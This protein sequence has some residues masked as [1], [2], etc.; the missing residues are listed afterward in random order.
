MV[1]PACK[2]TCR[3]H[4]VA[5]VSL[6]NR[7]IW[8]STDNCAILL[9]PIDRDLEELESLT[10]EGYN[11]VCFTLDEWA[12]IN[13]GPGA[14]NLGS[15]LDPIYP[16]TVPQRETRYIADYLTTLYRFFIVTGDVQLIA[17]HRAADPNQKRS[18]L[19]AVIPSKHIQDTWPPPDPDEQ[20]TYFDA[21]GHRWDIFDAD[22]DKLRV[23]V[24][25]PRPRKLFVWHDA[26]NEKKRYNKQ[27]L[28]FYTS[29]CDAVTQVQ[30]REYI[31]DIRTADC[32]RA[33]LLPRA[34]DVLM[35]R[36]GVA[37]FEENS[38]AVEEA[39]EIIAQVTNYAPVIVN[40]ASADDD[41]AKAMISSI[42][43][44]LTQ[45][46]PLVDGRGG[47]AYEFTPA[48]RE[49][50]SGLSGADQEREVAKLV[51]RIERQHNSANEKDIDPKL[52]ELIRELREER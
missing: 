10:K 31:P 6:L 26:V 23:V 3:E 18:I 13:P 38:A 4:H 29:E 35:N 12:L 44:V 34:Y 24:Y 15:G 33:K 19:R 51:R 16:P 49:R 7:D 30:F 36:T 5:F 2:D 52:A 8:V 39:L 42:G 28:Y 27:K 9:Q 21:F 32:L 40:C 41:L 43:G 46:I 14:A 37:A 48:E 22:G 1:R 25:E 50:L 47:F 17:D 20:H 11:P 45:G